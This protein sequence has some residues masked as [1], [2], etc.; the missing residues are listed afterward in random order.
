MLFLIGLVIGVFA[1][2]GMV[3]AA[4]ILSYRMSQLHDAEEKRVE[5]HIDELQ[6]ED[7][8]AR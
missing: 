2:G 8:A 1:G 3:L 4:A 6:P 7:E 5:R